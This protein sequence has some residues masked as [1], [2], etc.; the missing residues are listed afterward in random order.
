MPERFGNAGQNGHK[1]GWSLPAIEP[2]TK[3]LEL[4]MPAPP[5][6]PHTLMDPDRLETALQVADIMDGVFPQRLSDRDPARKPDLIPLGEEF[7]WELEN[8]KRLGK[9]DPALSTEECVK[10]RNML[11]G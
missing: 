7:E 11:L 9:G 8:A 6:E 10:H 4:L 2:V 1:P 5:A 3:A